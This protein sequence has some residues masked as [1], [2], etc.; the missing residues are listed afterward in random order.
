MNGFRIVM[1]GLL[2]AGNFLVPTA[3]RAAEEERFA[4]AVGRVARN[5]LMR[6]EVSTFLFRLDD[7]YF[8]TRYISPNETAVAARGNKLMVLR[9]SVLNQDNHPVEFGPTTVQFAAKGKDRGYTVSSAPMELIGRDNR[10]LSPGASK[11][12]I[13]WFEVPSNEADMR[14]NVRVGSSPEL[15]FDLRS[16]VRP[17]TGP[18]VDE[19]TGGI[20]DELEVIAKHAAPVGLFDATVESVAMRTGQILDGFLPG[21]GDPY[22]IVQVKLVNQTRQP[23]SLETFSI[24]PE[25]YDQQGNLIEW[26]RAM[27]SLKSPKFYSTVL[28]SGQSDV[29]QYVFHPKSGQVAKC[30]KLFDTTSGRRSIC[31]KL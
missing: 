2:L 3:A 22:Y 9:Y 13:V 30:V 27:V 16:Q 19:K 8:T 6:G 20:L 17:A 31:V 4:G 28:N 21:I 15:G 24:T 1:G 12:G 25:L 29:V 26:T 5:Y 11:A 10:E 7:A 14:L 23:L 18:F